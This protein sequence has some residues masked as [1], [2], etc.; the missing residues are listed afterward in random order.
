MQQVS[1]LK[2]FT[3]YWNFFSFWMRERLQTHLIDFTLLSLSRKRIQNIIFWWH[4]N[5][6]KWGKKTSPLTECDRPRQLSIH[7][8]LFWKAKRVTPTLI[9]NSA[10]NFKNQGSFWS[11]CNWIF[12]HFMSAS[13]HVS[14]TELLPLSQIY[15]RNICE[16]HCFLF[17]L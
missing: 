17:C 8:N 3:S 15:K 2:L 5:K 13:P 7:A 14:Q 10:T 12:L 9:R 6:F 1:K 16:A 11:L 4:L